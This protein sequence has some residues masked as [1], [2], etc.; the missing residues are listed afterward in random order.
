[1]VVVVVVVV[2]F[3]F[4]ANLIQYNGDEG[5]LVIFNL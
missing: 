2:V 4:F 5:F 3:F 1:M